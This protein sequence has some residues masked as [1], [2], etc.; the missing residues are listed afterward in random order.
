MLALVN[1]NRSKNNGENESSY[2]CSRS[3]FFGGSYYP[4]RR[5]VRDVMPIEAM[6]PSRSR[7]VAPSGTPGRLWRVVK[8][9]AAGGSMRGV[10][11]LIPQS[12]NIELLSGAV[13]A[14]SVDSMLSSFPPLPVHS[15]GSAD[16]DDDDD[17]EAGDR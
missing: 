17:D 13:V 15:A 12:L 16:D 1:T 11:W 6:S 9:G 10:S 7:S 8:T 14:V 3:Y 2:V 5:R 4:C